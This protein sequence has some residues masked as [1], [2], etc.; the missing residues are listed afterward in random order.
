MRIIFKNAKLKKICSDSK[1]RIRE[2]GPQRARLINL[3]L[4]QMWAAN[5]LEELR[6]LPGPRCH[7]LAQDR[8]GQLS[9]DIGHPYR[10]IFVVANDPVPEK[11]DGGLDW[12][13]VTAV[14]IWEVGDTHG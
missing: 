8:A 9:I 3:R 14:K 6:S 11:P 5:N 2:F 7:E 10:L 4:N 13:Q 1:R 12:K